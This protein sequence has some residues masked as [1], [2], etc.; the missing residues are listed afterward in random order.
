MNKTYREHIFRV[1]AVGSAAFI[2]MVSLTSCMLL[3]IQPWERNKL[4]NYYANE[5]NDVLILA[6]IKQVYDNSKSGGIVVTLEVDEEWYFSKYGQG[7]PGNMTVSSFSIQ[8]ANVSV[9]KEAGL[10]LGN[11]DGQDFLFVTST[12]IWWDGWDLPIIGM[13]SAD[14][15]TEYLSKE[16][17]RKNLLEWIETEK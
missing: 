10:S 9:L 3:S 2:L 6:Q 16:V 1:V 11:C 17:G 12:K 7:I 4:Y 14:G 13:I 15:T 5:N 8:E